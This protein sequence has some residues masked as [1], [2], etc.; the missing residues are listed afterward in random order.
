MGWRAGVS[1]GVSQPFLAIFDRL[2]TGK[3]FLP[4]LR[5]YILRYRFKVH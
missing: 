3:P 1:F 4:V 5:P 2:F